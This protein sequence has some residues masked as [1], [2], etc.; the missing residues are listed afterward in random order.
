MRTTVVVP[1]EAKVTAKDGYYR[2]R[3][4]AVK[5]FGRFVT[6]SVVGSGAL[7]ATRKG[8][9]TPQTTRNEVDE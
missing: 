5:I 6:S 7:Q 1:K 9:K 8:S 4:I 3:M 2:Q